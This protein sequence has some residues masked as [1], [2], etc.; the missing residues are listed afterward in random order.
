MLDMVFAVD[1][2]LAWHID[3]LDQNPDHYSFMKHVG[4]QSIVRLQQASAGV[5]YNTLLTIESQVLYYI[6]T[7]YFVPD[8]MSDTLT[9]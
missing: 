5:Y 8:L 3:N 1:D 9:Y 7:S 6:C 2:P 4:P